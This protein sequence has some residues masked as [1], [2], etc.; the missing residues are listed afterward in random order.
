MIG[1]NKQR[2]LNGKKRIGRSQKPFRKNSKTNVTIARN[3]S[4]S[5]KKH[6]AVMEEYFPVYRKTDTIP[7]CHEE[8]HTLYSSAITNQPF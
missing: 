4:K 5:Y 2:G 6:L 3:F 7:S 8:Y 1:K